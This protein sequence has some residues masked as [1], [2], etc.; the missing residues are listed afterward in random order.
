MLS[1]N[2]HECQKR[3]ANLVEG[4]DLNHR[5][6]VSKANKPYYTHRDRSKRIERE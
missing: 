3:I 2:Y 4:W 1:Q 6:L 5:S